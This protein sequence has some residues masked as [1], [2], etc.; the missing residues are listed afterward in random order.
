MIRSRKIEICVF[1]MFYPNSNLNL[2]VTILFQLFPFIIW[3]SLHMWGAC[4]ISILFIMK[5]AEH[6]SA[7][8]TP[9]WRK[10]YIN[11]EVCKTWILWLGNINT[12]SENAPMLVGLR[13]FQ[14]VRFPETHWKC[15]W[16][17][18]LYSINW[19]VVCVIFRG[20]Q[21]CRQVFQNRKWN[22][23]INLSEYLG[24]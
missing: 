20:I 22:G 23:N 2:M 8:I 24:D 14:L 15:S 4:T 9:E 18:P 5:F 12:M 13:D 21:V 16:C 11:Y 7:H 1:V 10:Q 19:T 3:Y 6:L 17:V